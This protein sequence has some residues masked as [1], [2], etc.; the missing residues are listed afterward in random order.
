MTDPAPAVTPNILSVSGLL[1]RQVNEPTGFTSPSGSVRCYLDSTTARC[2]I[3]DR[4]WAP[5][6]R[7]ASCAF[8]YGHGITLS[9]GQP[10]AFVCA[11]GTTLDAG[12][13]LA[14]RDSI[15]AGALRCESIATGITCR[16]TET[17][18]GF[19]LSREAYHLF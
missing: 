16:D 11:G 3:A 15:T 5:P 7:P 4:S 19:V 18:H 12:T 9:P 6:L 13:Q 10:A 8:D 2:D 14:D 1:N 17:R